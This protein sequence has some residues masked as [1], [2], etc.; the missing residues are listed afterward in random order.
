MDLKT[1][2]KE[3]LGNLKSDLPDA[4]SP[5]NPNNPTPLR[6]KVFYE[7]KGRNGKPA[8]IIEVENLAEEELAKLARH[9][10]TRLGIG[11]SVSGNE[12][13]LQGDQREKIK[14]I[15]SSFPR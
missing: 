13:L 7:R 10:K 5:N 8:T 12:I 9:L 2:W 1:D 4:D 15:I 11:G 3:I 14:P 6:Y